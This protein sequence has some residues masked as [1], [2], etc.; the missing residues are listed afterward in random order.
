MNITTN[1][2][3]YDKFLAPLLGVILIILTQLAGPA[4][5]DLIGDPQIVKWIQLALLIL[6]PI[7]GLL[8]TNKNTAALAPGQ[9]VVAKSQV[10]PG[11][12]VVEAHK[13]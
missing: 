4:G 9:V 10:V 7:S 8:V 1:F 5:A 11:A 12:Q 13:P 2:T 3:A 6:T